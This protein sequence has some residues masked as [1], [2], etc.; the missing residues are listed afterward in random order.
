LAVG[1]ITGAI[2]LVLALG[3]KPAQNII[4]PGALSFQHSTYKS[5]CSDCHANVSR[6]DS[7][8]TW[9][10][11]QS[12]GQLTNSQACLKCHN[13]GSQPLA[14]HALP[15][16]QLESLTVAASSNQSL[17]AG[18]F[19]LKIARTLGGNPK[20]RQTTW[21]CSTCH[22]EHRGEKN[23]LIHISDTQCQSCHAA[24]FSSFSQGHP[25]FKA[26]PFRRRTRIEFDHRSHLQTHFKA[27]SFS[28][29]A[30]TSCA[31]CHPP[32]PKG[33]AML[34]KTFEET[35]A[36]CHLDGIKGKGQASGPGITVIRLPG[37]DV[38][39]LTQR[40]VII[41]DWPES[42]DGS[43]TPF[44]EWLL[45]VTNLPAIDLLELS[46]ATPAQLNQAADLAWSIKELIY[47]L[48]VKGHAEL[49]RR[50][51]TALP[52]FPSQRQS[53]AVAGLLSPDVVQALRSKWFPNLDAEIAG[54]RAGKHLAT[55]ISTNTP[56]AAG[57]ATSNDLSPEEWVARGGWYRSDLEYSLSYRPTGH[58]DSF[59][60][61]WLELTAL[62]PDA[63]KLFTT[64]SNSKSPGQ[65]IKC[66]SIDE[67]PRPV[68]NW[69]AYQPDPFEH[70]FT[71]FSH[72]AHFSLLDDHG[73]QTCHSLDLNAPTGRYAESFGTNRNPA[74]FQSSFHPIKLAACTSCHSKKYA[75]ESCLECHNYHIGRF[76][77]TL[78]RQQWGGDSSSAGTTP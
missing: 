39:S 10:H 57:L 49:E 25:E 32:D 41:G 56:V 6:K 23:N 29:V 5:Q 36:A 64:L 35:C 19:M 40:G 71:H 27:E 14:A 43:M 51:Q 62:A 72:K 22:V 66:H 16:T 78:P 74:I 67:R 1:A 33:S 47:D 38:E 30:P 3:T 68:V 4:S 77:P 70:P 52:S 37:L 2:I 61:S 76:M 13:L 75:G 45:A 44:M 28:K 69:R 46:K 20:S 7:V 65:C 9:L 18:P 15:S 17:S 12:T 53:E 34:V 63:R 26:Y 54:H 59:L 50:L 55:N 60:R 42:A 58:A 11:H 31:D 48:S 21:A 73:C 24:Q 8:L